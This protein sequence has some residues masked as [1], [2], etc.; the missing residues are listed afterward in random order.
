MAT[1]RSRRVAS[2]YL[3][4]KS[5]GDVA[6]LL[7]HFVTEASLD[8]KQIEELRRMLAQKAKSGSS[9][10]SPEDP[11]ASPFRKGGK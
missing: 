3:R 11:P 2:T 7:V 6:A 8:Q 4:L 1:F 9:V 5:G 10:E